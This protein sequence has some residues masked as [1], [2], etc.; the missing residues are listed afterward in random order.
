[1]QALDQAVFLSKWAQ[2][3][4][5]IFAEKAAKKFIL[6]NEEIRSYSGSV[7]GSDN[8]NTPKDC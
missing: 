6:K 8:S 2:R 3:A 7:S 1:M 5:K 4:S